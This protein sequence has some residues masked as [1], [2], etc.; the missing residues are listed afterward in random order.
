M[1]RHM[2]YEGARVVSGEKTLIFLPGRGATFFCLQQIE[3]LSM[4]IRE[5]QTIKGLRS[6]TLCE[7]IMFYTNDV[8]LLGNT[9]TKRCS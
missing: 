2:L 5:D 4:A 6:S 1:N 9:V 3:P 8:M 7:E